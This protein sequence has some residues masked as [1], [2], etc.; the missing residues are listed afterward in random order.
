M[1]VTQAA[2][3]YFDRYQKQNNQH[4][5]IQ[6]RFIL[7]QESGKRDYRKSGKQKQA[8]CSFH[9]RQPMRLRHKMAGFT[10]MKMLFDRMQGIFFVPH[11]DQL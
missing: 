10:G 8:F 3:E 4:Q 6:R 5:P 11:A 1:I 9:T 2:C 7:D